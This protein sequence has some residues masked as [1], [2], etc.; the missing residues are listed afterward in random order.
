L[1][2]EVDVMWTGP[3]VCSP[4]LRADDAR[5]WTEA[6]RTAASERPGTGA[7]ALA[8]AMKLWL[9]TLNYLQPATDPDGDSVSLFI[10]GPQFVKP[11]GSTN[12]GSIFIDPGYTNSGPHSIEVSATDSSG[13]SSTRTV[14]LEVIDTGREPIATVI[15]PMHGGL[16]VR[17]RESGQ[18]AL[19][20]VDPDLDDQDDQFT[21]ELKSDSYPTSAMSVRKTPQPDLVYI[22]VV[23]KDT[24]VGRHRLTATIT[25]RFGLTNSVEMI[26]NVLRPDIAPDIEANIAAGD[27]FINVGSSRLLR[28]QIADP[29]YGIRD[30]VLS[31][32]TR[33][34]LDFLKARGD[35][36][37][38]LATFPDAITVN[39]EI[40]SPFDVQSYPGETNVSVTTHATDGYSVAT[41]TLTMRARGIAVQCVF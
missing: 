1:P 34:R 35:I 27:R 41:E 23:P 32:A 40:K 14:D 26:L 17:A 15:Q 8:T 7:C 38:T 10:S 11:R 19:K 6:L 18:Y 21:F 13:S 39:L 20:V 16:A 37:Y 33:A 9:W 2:D 12:A 28:F 3:T 22:M 31:P 36:D 4:T 29:G 5:G 24:D 25:D 30:F